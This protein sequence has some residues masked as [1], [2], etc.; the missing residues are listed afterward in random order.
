VA[1]RVDQVDCDVVDDERHDRGLDR[2]AA[3]PFQGQEIG[4]GAAV[5]DAA[6]RVDHTGGVEEPLG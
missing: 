5:V 3:L 6:G 4:L 1:G 2:D